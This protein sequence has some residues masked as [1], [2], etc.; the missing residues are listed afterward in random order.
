[1]MMKFV[2]ASDGGG[3]VIPAVYNGVSLSHVTQISVYGTHGV[4][5]RGKKLE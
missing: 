2:F 4:E 5:N 3:K 1:M